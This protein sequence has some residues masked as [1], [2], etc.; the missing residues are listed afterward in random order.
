MYDE[1]SSRCVAQV[2]F[3][4]KNW[5]LKDVGSDGDEYFRPFNR[6]GEENCWC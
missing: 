3:N 1:F 5:L 4:R 6:C 2:R